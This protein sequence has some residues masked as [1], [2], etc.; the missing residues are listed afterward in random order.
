MSPFV[1]EK[2]RRYMFKFHPKIAR[3]W[4]NEYGSTIKPKKKARRSSKK[5]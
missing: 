4:T 3:R 2:Q 1:S 5:R